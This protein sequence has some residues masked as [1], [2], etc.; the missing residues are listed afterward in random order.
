MTA[1]QKAKSMGLK[2]LKELSETIDTSVQ[3]LSNWHKYKP[4]RFHAACL[5]G[6]IMVCTQ[7]SKGE[8]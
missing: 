6:C 2:S 8:K 7:V 3:T 1:S 5:G 4:L